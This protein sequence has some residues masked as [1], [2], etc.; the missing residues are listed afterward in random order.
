MSTTAF[1]FRGVAQALGRN[2]QPSDAIDGQ[3]PQPVAELGQ[4]FWPR[5]F[6]ASPAVVG[7]TIRLDHKSYLIVGVAAPRFTWQDGGVYLPLKTDSGQA[8]SYFTEIRPN[9]GVTPAQADPP[10]QPRL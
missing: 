7:K 6:N 1:D 3:D 5:H 10:P 4:K 8:L 9:P 2:L